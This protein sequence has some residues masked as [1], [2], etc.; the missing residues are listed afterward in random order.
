MSVGEKEIRERW[1]YHS[2]TTETQSLHELI[3][4]AYISFAMF[5][6]EYLPDGRAKSTAFTNLQQSSMWANYG[7]AQLAPVELPK[8]KVP[9]TAKPSAPSQ[10]RTEGVTNAAS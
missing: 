8:P 5:L 1:G 7:I 9:V 3:R 10:T 2:P 6:D 4:E